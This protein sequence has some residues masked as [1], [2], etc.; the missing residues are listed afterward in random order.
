MLDKYRLLSAAEGR[1]Y[2]MDLVCY[3]LASVSSLDYM[4]SA[5][6]P[7]GVEYVRVTGAVQNFTVSVLTD[8][9]KFSSQ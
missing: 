5:S 2:F 6:H 8:E 9:T 3:A 7:W 4:R 1:L